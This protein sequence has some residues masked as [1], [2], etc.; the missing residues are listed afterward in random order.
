MTALSSV[1]GTGEGRGLVRPDRAAA[2]P[3]VRVAAW[4]SAAAALDLLL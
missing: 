3:G 2:G 4:G 1:A